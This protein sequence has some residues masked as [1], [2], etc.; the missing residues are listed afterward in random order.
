MAQ[1]YSDSII[2]QF[3]PIV[4]QFGF[5]EPRWDYDPEEE[6]VRVQFQNPR[7]GNAVQ[8]DCHVQDDKYSANYC[9]MEGEW[10]MCVEGKHKKL[11]AL[12]VTL[13]HWIRKHCL[14]CRAAA[15]EEK[16]DV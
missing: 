2:E 16:E 15:E 5:S 3:Q 4:A 11:P 13:P 6:I 14:E 12:K 9:R 8:I 7:R 1:Q 10:K